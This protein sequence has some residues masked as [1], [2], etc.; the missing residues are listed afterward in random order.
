MITYIR[1]DGLQMSKEALEDIR[2]A[3]QDLHGDEYLP[4]QPRVYKCAVLS[5]M[6]VH[7]QAAC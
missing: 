2:S 3:V 7:I 6:P 1:T 4:A 5:G